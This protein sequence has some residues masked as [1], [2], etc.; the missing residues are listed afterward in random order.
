MQVCFI[1]LMTTLSPPFE[2]LSGVKPQLMNRHFFITNVSAWHSF[3]M[4]GFMTDNIIITGVKNRSQECMGG[5]LSQFSNQGTYLTAL[6]LHQQCLS[7]YEWSLY[8]CGASCPAFYLSDI[9]CQAGH[10]YTTLWGSFLFKFGYFLVMYFI[11]NC[12]FF[13]TRLILRS[14]G[15]FI[16]K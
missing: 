10:H 14:S 13:C 16:F 12:Y 6:Y 8:L 7:L 9:S 11:S 15:I 2:K 3:F 1:N 5:I 4:N